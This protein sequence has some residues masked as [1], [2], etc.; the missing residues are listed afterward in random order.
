[1]ADAAAQNPT[2]F[3]L[4]IGN[5]DVLGYALAGGDQG[6]DPI[7][8]RA[9]FE[10]SINGIVAGLS[11]ASGGAIANI[12]DIL[13]IPFFNATAY[14]VFPITSEEQANLLNGGIE[15][16]VRSNRAAFRVGVEINVKAGI[17]AKQIEEGKS[18]AEAEAIASGIIASPEGQALVDAETDKYLNQV[19]AALPK[20]EKS[21][22][23]PFLI[24]DAPNPP[25]NPTGLRAATENDLI[26]L[27]ARDFLEEQV[28]AGNAPILTGAYVL[29]PSEQEK[30]KA[31]I[32]EYNEVIK[33]AAGSKY[34]YVDMFDFF[35]KVKSGYTYQ[36]VG[37]NTQFVL[38][39]A[40]SLDG[41]H[42]T[43][44]GYA[45]AANEFIRSI[46]TKYDAKLSWINVNDY[47]GITFP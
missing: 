18:E 20:V 1:M 29:D 37:Y 32:V 6:T 40:F 25:T 38:G 2:F 21:D 4:W 19:V 24:Q 47:K 35:N 16:R 15:A 9:T 30:I 43:Q 27:T 46:N 42:L 39:G 33:T 44:R 13:A 22:N 28:K 31:A 11:G 34:A 14:N 10:G 23:N 26:L 5:N 41:V 36:G 45:L 17:K 8:P 12:P 7:T 3:T